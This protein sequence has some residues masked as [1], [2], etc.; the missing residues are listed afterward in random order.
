MR[1]TRRP[2]RTAAQRNGLIWLKKEVRRAGQL[3]PGRGPLAGGMERS[4]NSPVLGQSQIAV[5]RECGQAAIDTRRQYRTPSA[6]EL[7]SIVSAGPGIEQS[8]KNTDRPE[9][10]VNRAGHSS[11]GFPADCVLA[12]LYAKFSLGVVT[13]NSFPLFFDRQSIWLSF[14]LPAGSFTMARRKCVQSFARER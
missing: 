8:A 11:T 4:I 6:A 5:P 14:S 12:P 3:A 9:Q 7:S 13:G 10:P 2:R 1:L